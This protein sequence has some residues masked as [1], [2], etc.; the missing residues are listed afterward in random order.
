MCKV[1]ELKAGSPAG[2][3]VCKMCRQFREWFI[4]I[5]FTT[6]RRRIKAKKRKNLFFILTT[7]GLFLFPSQM[8]SVGM[9]FRGGIFFRQKSRH[10]FRAFWD[11]T[12]KAEGLSTIVAE[13][14]RECRK[15]L[16]SQTNS[17]NHLSRKYGKAVR[18]LHDDTTCRFPLVS[19]IFWM[20]FRKNMQHDLQLAVDFYLRLEK[21]K[22][23][24]RN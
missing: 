6:L 24:F 16:K 17:L 18:M 23:N 9:T 19:I 7:I 22:A 8:A 12:E 5:K 14:W 3:I 10:T 20:L 21:A 11:Y 13:A 15:S 2:T 1:W 4:N